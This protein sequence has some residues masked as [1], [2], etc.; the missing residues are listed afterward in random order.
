MS[1]PGQSLSPHGPITTVALPALGQDGRE[2]R[3]PVVERDHL[4]PSVLYPDAQGVPS[5]LREVL[6][7]AGYQVRQSHELLPVPV[8]DGRHAVVP[9]DQLDIHYVGNH[10]E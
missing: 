7:R 6:R 8:E 10:V 9:V 3:L 2:I 1:G 5:Q 4:D